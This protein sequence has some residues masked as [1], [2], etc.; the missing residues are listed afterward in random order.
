MT[1]HWTVERHSGKKNG[2]FREVCCGDEAKANKRFEEIRDQLRQGTVVLR[3]GGAAMAISTAPRL[4]AGKLKK[5]LACAVRALYLYGGGMERSARG[6][7][8]DIVRLIEPKAAKL[9]DENEEAAYQRYC[10][11]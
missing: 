1:N 9:L 7:L 5:V 6:E 11:D 3:C 4:T 2:E 8:Y 10:H